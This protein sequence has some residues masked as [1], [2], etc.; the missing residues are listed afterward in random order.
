MKFNKYYLM[1]ALFCM[2]L[3]SCSDDVTEG[4][5]G[6]TSIEQPE[7]VKS[8]YVSFN[9][10]FTG[11]SSR[12]FDESIKTIADA[13]KAVKDYALFVFKNEEGGDALNTLELYET[14][15]TPKQESDDKFQTGA[16]LISSGSKKVFVVVNGA[17]NGLVLDEINKQL[18][19]N[20]T[21]NKTLL[22]DFEKL[23]FD[24]TYGTGTGALHNAAS[25]LGGAE[26]DL[27]KGLLMSGFATATLEDGVSKDDAENS[28]NN[29]IEIG[30]DRASAKITIG[31]D[32]ADNTANFD[33]NLFIV[34]ASSSTIENPFA[35]NS[36]KPELGTISAVNYAMFNQ[37]TAGFLVAHEGTVVAN[38]NKTIFE[39]P[40]YAYAS[41]NDLYSD[42]ATKQTPWYYQNQSEHGGSK[43]VDFYTTFGDATTSIGKVIALTGTPADGS[44]ALNPSYIPENTNAFPVKGNTTYAMLEATFKP[45]ITRSVDMTTPIKVASE[46]GSALFNQAAKPISGSFL[47]SKEYGVFFGIA[48]DAGDAIP[49]STA[50]NIS[51]IIGTD[52]QYANNVTAIKAIAAKMISDANVNAQTTAGGVESAAMKAKKVTIDN[53][54]LSSNTTAV[55]GNGGKWLVTVESAGTTDNVGCDA[56][57][58]DNAKYFKITKIQLQNA[59]SNGFELDGD[60][61]EN[62]KFPG[63]ISTFGIYPAG[64]CYYRLN[65]QDEGLATGISPLRYAVMRNYWYQI[66][67]H[68]F[69]D[70]G[71]PNPAI[72]AGA[73]TDALGADTHVSAT[74]TVKPWSVKNMKPEVGL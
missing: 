61:I 66:S 41:E 37:N 43:Y 70:L 60:G 54:V 34:A 57:A 15:S 44:A 53:I 32:A 25:I 59:G 11:T 69:K 33:N 28:R 1:S 74:I 8:T 2:A 27:G 46:A 29:H 3:A 45:E 10:N 36:L 52:P 26:T 6:N 56:N 39:D 72:A 19:E 23:K 62:A 73:A 22:S 5:D 12:A 58:A 24:M 71:Y 31:V 30:V 20:L 47:Y 51:S 7:S 65:I 21:I 13:E 18:G 55:P 50:D 48:A 42:G 49:R 35:A 16:Y 63:K 68:S 67:L 64:K 40:N 17:D 4:Q 9:L 38:D 14:G